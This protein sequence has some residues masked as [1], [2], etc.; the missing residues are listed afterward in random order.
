MC[1]H[2]GRHFADHMF[3]K[4]FWKKSFVLILIALKRIHVGL[5]EN[6]HIL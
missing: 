3:K 5:V 2:D 1:Q 6:T 4:I